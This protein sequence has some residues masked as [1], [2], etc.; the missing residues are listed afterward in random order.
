MKCLNI[1]EGKNKNKRLGPRA[2]ARGQK[3][4]MASICDAMF[5]NNDIFC[6]V[7]ITNEAFEYFLQLFLAL[8]N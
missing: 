1:K 3:M 4:V 6:T 8:M 7:V 5:F 2:K